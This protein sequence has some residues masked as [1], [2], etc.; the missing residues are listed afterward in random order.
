[1]IPKTKKD[2]YKT[3]VATYVATTGGREKFESQIEKAAEKGQLARKQKF[4]LLAVVKEC[5]TAKAV[6]LPVQPTNK[7][8]ESIAEQLAKKMVICQKEVLTSAEVAAYLGL[9]LSH[10]YRLTMTKKIPYYR[11]NGGLIFFN[12]KE[13]EEWAQTNKFRSDKEVNNVLTEE[14]IERWAKQK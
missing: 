1:M 4:D 5:C 8:A 10:L 9:S 7:M 3:A 14:E 13:V 2:L 6:K 12:R 11:P